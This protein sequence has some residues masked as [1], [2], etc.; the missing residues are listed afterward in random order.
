MFIPATSPSTQTDPKVAVTMMSFY[1]EAKFSLYGA[2]SLVV[3]LV[4][5]GIFNGNIQGS[6][7]S[8]LL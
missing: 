2:K 3:Q 1:V 6:N 5:L 8:L 4:P 7:L